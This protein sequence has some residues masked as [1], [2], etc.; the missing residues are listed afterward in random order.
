M[1][2]PYVMLADIPE[3][4]RDALLNRLAKGLVPAEGLPARLPQWVHKVPVWQ[5]EGQAQPPLLYD[6]QAFPTSMQFEPISVSYWLEALR[7]RVDVAFDQNAIFWGQEGYLHVRVLEQP[8]DS[9]TSTGMPGRRPKGKQ[10]IEAEFRRR[11]ASNECEH[12]LE[13]EARALC[14]WFAKH[15][16]MADQPSQKTVENNIRAAHRGW[17]DR[18]NPTK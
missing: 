4:E 18:V 11:A 13:G 5:L 6:K 17:R 9:I 16:P 14:A 1:S 12:S 2:P 7:D 8:D 10:L 15:H 3:A